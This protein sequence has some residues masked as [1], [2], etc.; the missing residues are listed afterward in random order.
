MNIDKETMRVLKT[1]TREQWNAILKVANQQLEGMEIQSGVLEMKV[2][3]VVKKIGVPLN[4]H[5]YKYLQDAILL[6][7]RDENN[8]H[9]VTVNIYPTIA[10]KYNVTSGSVERCIRHAIQTACSKGKPELL[11]KIFGSSYLSEGC[12]PTNAYAIA[13]LADYVI[14]T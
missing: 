2:Q 6:V 9:R 8:I 14:T 7:C 10:E 4:Y 13:C 12:K 3:D 1:V 5:G 11:E